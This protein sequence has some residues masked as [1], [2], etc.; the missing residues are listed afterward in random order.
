MESKNEKEIRARTDKDRRPV[1]N[2]P[3]TALHRNEP[4]FNSPQNQPYNLEQNL[5]IS[6]LETKYDEG[7]HCTRL[8]SFNC[9]F[10]LHEV[11]WGKFL[12]LYECRRQ[13]LF[14]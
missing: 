12:A 6:I 13:F 7:D 3:S 9:T 8:S 1:S 10:F 14:K 4:L 2:D 11:F 5:Q